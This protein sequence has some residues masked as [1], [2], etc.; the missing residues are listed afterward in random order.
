MEG[1]TLLLLV[2]VDVVHTGN[3]FVGLWVDVEKVGA[4]LTADEVI[5]DDLFDVGDLNGAV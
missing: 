1:D 4:D 3:L 2:E 5:V